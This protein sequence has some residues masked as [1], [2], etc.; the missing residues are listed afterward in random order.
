[1]FGEKFPDVTFFATDKFPYN[2]RIEE[3]GKSVKLSGIKPRDHPY[4]MFTKSGG[5][6]EGYIEYCIIMPVFL[7]DP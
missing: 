2:T 7:S 6:V 1:M 3:Y 5:R 4:I